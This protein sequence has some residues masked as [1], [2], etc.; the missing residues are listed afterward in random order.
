M[1]AK[2]RVIV[3]IQ[4]PE[5]AMPRAHFAS[6]VRRQL[7]L[8]MASDTLQAIRGC[9]LVR[10]IVVVSPSPGL[11]ALAAHFDAE[12]AHSGQGLG[13][14]RAIEQ[15]LSK[16]RRAGDQMVAAI[17]SDLPALESAELSD[18]LVQAGRRRESVH[19]TDLGGAGVTFCAERVSNFQ[20]CLAADPIRRRKPRGADVKEFVPGLRCDVDSSDGLRV[21]NFLGLGLHTQSAVDD[22]QLFSKVAPL[23]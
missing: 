5:L 3:P 23:V 1:S 2:F 15:A 21:A 8:A 17:V 6:A 9:Q 13:L 18:L 10:D 7:S 16:T 19:T 14:N 11:S 20:S 12:F 4:D 22:M